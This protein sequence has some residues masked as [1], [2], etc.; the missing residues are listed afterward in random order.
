MQAA[1]LE[2]RRTF[3]GKYLFLQSNHQM[4]FHLYAVNFHPFPLQYSKD[5][6]SLLNL[7][8]MATNPFLYSISSF[9]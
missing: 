7:G 5:V 9:A 1:A 8:L 2:T 3:T 4:T 6:I